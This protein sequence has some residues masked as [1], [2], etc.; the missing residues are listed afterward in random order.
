MILLRKLFSKNKKEDQGSPKA[1]IGKKLLAGS[2]LG[3]G[4][5]A[6]ND[7]TSVVSNKLA[8]SMGKITATDNNT[9]KEKLLKEAKKQGTRVVKDSSIGDNAAYTGTK[10]GKAARN[11]I[12]KIA[13]YLRKEDSG[14]LAQNLNDAGKKVGT[15]KHLGKDRIILGDGFQ[16][17]DI[18]SHELGHSKHYRGRSK[19]VI[20]VAAHNTMPVSKLAMSPLGTGL[21][22]IHG[23]KA[24]QK[25]VKNKRAGKKDSTWNKVRAAAIP[26][27]MVAPVLI[28][29]GSAS[30]KGLKMM[31]NAGASKELM[32][33]SRKRLAQAYGT[34]AS[35]S[36]SPVIAGQLGREVGK[37]Y[38]KS[39]DPKKNK[40]T[41]K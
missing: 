8:D 22:A 12:A 28:A 31:K 38:E 23:F 40:S 24:G 17:A 21:S 26:A 3:I 15:W 4:A 41:K 5:I 16:D 32:K 35:K 11:T 2:G 10:E 1:G 37:V 25:T 20:A 18:L 30:L 36:A 33:Q 27:A 6:V 29:E 19:N 14:N 13:K 9:V 34:Y 7:G 39:K